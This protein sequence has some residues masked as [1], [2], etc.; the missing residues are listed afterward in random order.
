M[1]KIFLLFFITLIS[2]NFSAF[3]FQKE[4]KKIN[5][6]IIDKKTQKP[7]PYCSVRINNSFKGTYSNRLGEFTINIDSTENN[8]LIFSH[9]NYEETKVVTSNKELKVEL[10]PVIN[11]LEEVV[12]KKTKFVKDNYA[13]DLVK[14]SYENLKISSKERK[15][16]EA[17]Y[18]QKSTNNLIYNEFSEIIFNCKYSTDG[19]DEWSIIEGRYALKKEA[20]NNK[21]FTLFTKILKSNQPN[22]NDLIFLFNPNFEYHYNVRVVKK[23]K[24][25]KGDVAVVKFMPKSNDIPIFK[26]E[27]FID[28]KTKNLLRLESFIQDD[29]LDLVKLGE[30]ESSKKDYNLSYQMN[31]TQ[32]PDLGVILDYVKVNQE[33]DYYVDNVKKTRVTSSSSLTFFEHFD[34]NVVSGIGVKFKRKHSD[35]N[36]INKLGYN[37]EFWENNPIVTRTPI[38]LDVIESFETNS[39]FESIFINSRNQISLSGKDLKDDELINE[40][41]TE[42]KE[43]NKVNPIE[44]IYLHT[45]KDAYNIGE[46]LWYSSYSTLGDNYKNLLSSELIYVDLVDK[47]DNIT[48]SQSLKVSDGRSEGMIQIPRELQSGIYTLKGYSNWMKN[49]D[50]NFFFNKKITIKGVKPVTKLVK[51]KLITSNQS[52]INEKYQLVFFPEG[53]YLVEDL[54]VRVAFEA[55]NSKGIPIQIKGK[56]FNSNNEYV[57]GVN[58]IYKGKG[59]FYFIPKKGNSYYVKLLD[60]EIHQLPS[61][62]SEGYS[63]FVNNLDDNSVNIK[64]QASESLKE[65]PFYI[66]AQIENKKI[67]EGKFEFGGKLIA[68]VEISKNKL[69]SGVMTVTIFDNDKNA[70]SERVV[71]INNDD[72]LSIKLNK[73]KSKGKINLEIEVLDSNGIPVKTSLSLSVTNSKKYNKNING[74]NILTYFLLES[75]TKGKIQD[76]MFL[77]DDNKRATKFKLDLIMQV[78]GWRRIKWEKIKDRTVKKHLFTSGIS[79]SGLATLYNLPVKNKEIQIVALSQ[80]KIRT[81]KVLTN[82][83]GRFKLDNISHQGDIDVVFNLYEKQLL[84]EGL[85]I[86]LD[87]KDYKIS[88]PVP[89]NNKNILEERLAYYDEAFADKEDDSFFNNDNIK[90][91]EV[92]IKKRRKRRKEIVKA[93]PSMYDVEPD[94]T[95]FTEEMFSAN[96]VIDLLQGIPGVTATNSYV[97][98]RS[99]TGPPLFVIDGM[100]QPRDSNLSIESSSDDLVSGAVLRSSSIPTRVSQMSALEIERIEVLKG[101][102]AAIFGL[103]GAGGV[104]LIYTKNTVIEKNKIKVPRFLIKG[105]ALAKEFYA[106]KS[107]KIIEKDKIETVYWNPTIITDDKGKASVEFYDRGVKN[108]QFVVEGCSIFE[109]IGVAIENFR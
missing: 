21:N 101:S 82:S 24:S 75:E 90:L 103:R 55:V 71:Y 49:Y 109:S 44:K 47:N 14:K 17:L 12:L 102:S 2:N 18:R 51:N 45:D 36:K 33:F 76:P 35:W 28:I 29:R 40:L 59:S 27:A 86:K 94:D 105:S 56:V 25:K 43:Y 74:S 50:N 57:V 54:P 30:K 46:K 9:I 32:D 37:K 6:V 58:S 72:R 97:S 81:Y 93:S 70:R 92:K 16:A 63:M 104:I 106:P 62:I 69:P 3:S 64:V 4:I 7:I 84:Q 100:I 66:I 5:G 31:F 19:I 89:I 88:V 52:D 10:L 65:K 87:E 98:I 85:K 20:V 95:V 23:I 26:G 99:S 80:N 91:D 77:I 22:T 60:G 108:L 68:D 78:N 41:F 67:Y 42:I 73:R 107:S 15:F 53:G 8:E 38:E 96:T 39:S 11:I 34:K 48:I 1:R 13:I 83:F 79:I 61:V